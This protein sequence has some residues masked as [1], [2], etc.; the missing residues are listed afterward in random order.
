[1]HV[2]AGK[3][4]AFHEALNAGIQGVPAAVVAN[5][6][7]LAEPI[8]GGGYKLVSGGTEKHLILVDLRPR[9]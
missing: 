2:I 5:A 1:M 4:V 6:K 3:A 9:T 8:M 7:A